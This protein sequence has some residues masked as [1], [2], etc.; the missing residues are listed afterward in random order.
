VNVVM[1]LL[2]RDEEDVVDEQLRYHLEHG[3]DFVIATDHRSVDGT[4]E[5]LRRY[6]RDGHLHYISEQREEYLQAEFVTRMA[7]LAAT[8]YRA[9]WVINADADEFWWCRDGSFAEIFGSVP[10]RFGAVLGFWRHFVLRP[11][12]DRP[13]F[14]RMIWRRR[15]TADWTEQYHVSVKAAHRAHPQVEVVQGNHKV[16][17]TSIATLREWLPIEVLH[18]PLRSVSQLRR[19]FTADRQK[20]GQTA[21]KTRIEVELEARGAER[22]VR[23]LVVDND[24]LSAGLA[25]GALTR[26]TRVRDALRQDGA[27]A[28]CRPTLE[29][30]VVLATE[31]SEYASLIPGAKQLR[32]LDGL[33]QRAEVIGA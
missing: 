4:T 1:T 16:L 3:V 25:R 19:K 15:P 18:F 2:V 8:D 7:R 30:D 20:G 13:F 22:V 33:R 27:G 17:G 31:Y 12:D 32:L 26:D 29:D 5:I 6:E 10:E 24:A 28:E 14:E 11:D 21:Y 9:D 23:D